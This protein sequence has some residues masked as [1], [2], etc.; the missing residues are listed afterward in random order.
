MTKAGEGMTKTGIPI[1]QER[2]PSMF[3]PNP[4]T[5]DASALNFMLQ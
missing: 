4:R 3:G 1:E 2:G 5:K